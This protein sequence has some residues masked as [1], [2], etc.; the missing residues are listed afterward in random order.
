MEKTI[1]AKV[2]SI[3]KY[4][5]S[6]DKESRN[7]TYVNLEWS[8]YIEELNQKVFLCSNPYFKDYI[9][10]KGKANKE[11]VVSI[12]M[13]NN[14]K[15]L[16]QNRF[17]LIFKSEF[18]NKIYTLPIKSYRARETWEVISIYLMNNNQEIAHVNGI[19]AMKDLLVILGYSESENK[20]ILEYLKKDLLL[21]INKYTIE[22]N[23]LIQIYLK[24][25]LKTLC[26]IEKDIY[27]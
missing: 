26:E 14:N 13:E 4:L 1:F 19:Q 10:R 2:D 5:N 3:S 11:Q 9:I 17:F 22:K 15:K 8:I 24:M 18:D 20:K 6:L 21:F 25:L 12:D 27:L 23:L 16:W 7:G